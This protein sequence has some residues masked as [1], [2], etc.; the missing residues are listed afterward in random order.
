MKKHL[1][2]MAIAGA[3]VLAGL[4]AFGVSPT[5]ALPYAFLLACPVMMIWM[6]TTMSHN[7]GTGR[8]G[9]GHDHSKDADSEVSRSP[10][11]RG[12]SVQSSHHD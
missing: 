12:S 1:A 7:S 6:M 11:S 10:E 2:Q 5:A 3:I 4:V 9:C 8:A